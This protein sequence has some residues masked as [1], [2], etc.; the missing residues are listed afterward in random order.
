MKLELTDGCTGDILYIDD[1]NIEDFNIEELKNVLFLL[2][3]RCQN[4]YTIRNIIRDYTEQFGE[5]EDLGR[6]D[7]CGDYSYKYTL[8]V[9]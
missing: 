8:K 5:M 9:N 3:E 6:C 2:I 7:Q 4:I 1:K